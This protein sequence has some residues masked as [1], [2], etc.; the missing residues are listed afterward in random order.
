MLLLL[1]AHRS[2]SCGYVITCYQAAPRI[3][4]PR[5]MYGQPPFPGFGQYK[6]AST[7]SR[8][9]HP[10]RDPFHPP[11]GPRTGWWPYPFPAIRLAVSTKDSRLLATPQEITGAVR[12]Q[13][14]VTPVQVLAMSKACRE[15]L[16]ITSPNQ[17]THD[18][19]SVQGSNPAQLAPPT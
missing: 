5:I 11:H 7:T 13:V 10:H 19:W 17:G 2:I 1:L 16:Y 3:R 8:S 4:I 9:F 15:E 18:L 12:I 14:Q 6:V